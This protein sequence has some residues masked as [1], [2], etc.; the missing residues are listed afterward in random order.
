MTQSF[1]PKKGMV[2][3]LGLLQAKKTKKGIF[4]AKGSST[5]ITTNITNY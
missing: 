1:I 4:H 2:R 3:E 5:T